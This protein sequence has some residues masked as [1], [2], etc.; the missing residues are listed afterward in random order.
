MENVTNFK[1]EEVQS[2]REEV[3]EALQAIAAKYNSEINIGKIRYSSSCD[4]Q[5]EF[6][7]M[8]TDATGQS[9]AMTK[10]AQSFIDNFY[11]HRIPV[12][13]LNTEFI[14]GGFKIVITG[15]KTANSKYPITYM[16]DGKPYKCSSSH[17]ARMVK[18][19]LPSVGL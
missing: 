7:K 1:L 9:Y 4:M 18:I 8:A 19:G 3:A 11:R 6:A 5:I 16:Q 13:A 17:M 14:H 10:E 2:M 12:E 15:F